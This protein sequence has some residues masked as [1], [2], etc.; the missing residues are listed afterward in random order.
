MRHLDINLLAPIL[1]MRQN[2]GGT[3]NVLNYKQLRDEFKQMNFERFKE[4]K[5]KRKVIDGTKRKFE[6][7][8]KHDDRFWNEI[9]ARADKYV[10]NEKSNN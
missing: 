10:E 9:V 1:I 4:K 3:M 8:N 2:Q 6:Y 7:R 5:L